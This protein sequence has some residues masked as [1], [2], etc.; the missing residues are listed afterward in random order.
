MDFER[1]SIGH[2]RDGQGT[3]PTEGRSSGL[4]EMAPNSG[5]KVHDMVQDIFQDMDAFYDD[6]SAED[7]VP[8]APME[9]T[10]ASF[11]DGDDFEIGQETTEQGPTFVVPEDL[12]PLFAGA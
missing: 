7:E 10:T 3:S 8:L 1:Q 6:M 9:P 5:I 2:S 4:P 12:Q 11:A